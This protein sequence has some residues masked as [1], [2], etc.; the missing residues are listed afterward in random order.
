MVNDALKQV[1]DLIKPDVELIKQALVQV[2]EKKK[3]DREKKEKLQNRDPE[4][5]LDD[6]LDRYKQMD[7]EMIP[8]KDWKFAATCVPIEIHVEIVKLAYER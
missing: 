7:A 8:E 4:I 5:D 1:V 3:R 2:H 6:L